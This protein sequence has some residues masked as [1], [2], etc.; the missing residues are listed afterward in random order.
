MF[1]F[2]GVSHLGLVCAKLP[3]GIVHLNLSHCGLTSKGVNG[4]ATSLSLNPAT[5]STL[6]YLNLSGNNLKDEINVSFGSIFIMYAEVPSHT[7]KI[8]LDK[9]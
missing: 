3:K 6:S 7:L 9:V 1:I 2:V 8:P 4:L 5:P